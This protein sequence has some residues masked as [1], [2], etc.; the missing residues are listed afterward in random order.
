M[1]ARP[2][3]FLDID[4]VLNTYHHRIRQ[5][6]FGGK[7]SI[8]NWCP[9]SC[10]NIVNLCREFDAHIIISSNWKD[11]Y[12]LEE[13]QKI[14][15]DNGIPSSLIMDMTPSEVERH[16]GAEFRGVEIQRWLDEHAPDHQSFL[17]IDDDS[18]VLDSQKQRL[19]QVD[20]EDGFA[21][22]KALDKA[23]H[24]LSNGRKN[25]WE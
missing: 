1:K 12:K 5:K 24:I 13:M 21:N 17:I 4:G 10:D 18:T 22:P 19:V 20:P 25:G 9:I 3:I 16:D 11:L 23:R 8:H 14:F 15:E 7:S 2:Y 6:Q